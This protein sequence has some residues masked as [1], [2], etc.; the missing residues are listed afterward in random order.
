MP[1]SADYRNVIDAYLPEWLLKRLELES[2][3]SSKER[4][5]LRSLLLLH[6]VSAHAA[7]LPDGPRNATS[8]QR[9]ALELACEPDNV[10]SL[11]LT[12]DELY[13]P[14]HLEPSNCSVQRFARSSGCSLLEA[15]GGGRVQVTCSCQPECALQQDKRAFCAAVASMCCAVRLLQ[16]LSQ[17]LLAELP[18]TDGSLCC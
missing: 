6:W 9:F 14:Q 13:L 2:L 18:M 3:A 5:E 8:R 7:T 15:G 1:V 11:K 12:A 16:T 4:D 10:L 17:R